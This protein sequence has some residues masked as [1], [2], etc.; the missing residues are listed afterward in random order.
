MHQTYF[1]VEEPR[2]ECVHLTGSF[3]EVENHQVKSSGRQK[4]RV[5]AA[6]LLSTCGDKSHHA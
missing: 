3:T 1:D 5:G 4:V 6:E 2:F